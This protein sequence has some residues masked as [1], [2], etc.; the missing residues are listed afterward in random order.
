M[1]ANGLLN[2]RN[3]NP[4]NSMLSSVVSENPNQAST[5][6]PDLVLE[7]ARID[8]LESYLKD[9][10]QEG[11]NE[12]TRWLREIRL[13]HEELAWH[14]RPSVFILCMIVGMLCISDMM[15]RAPFI[16]LMMNKVCDNLVL[17]AKENS[18][19][20]IATEC[21]RKQVQQVLA[22]VTSITIITSGI[23]N[24]FLS[25]KWGAFSDRVGRTR[26]FAYIGM[27]RLVGISVLYYSISPSAPYNKWLLIIPETIQSLGGGGLTVIAIGNSY[28]LDIVEPEYR[29]VAISLMMSTLY[30]TMGLGPMISSTLTN[31]ST[32]NNFVPIHVSLLLLVLFIILC[33]LLLVE[34]R[35]NEAMN[36]S[37]L[38]FQQK[39][40]D[41]NDRIDEITANSNRFVNYFSRF[42][43]LQVMQ[44]KGLLSPLNTLWIKPTEAG[45]LK[46]RYTVILL[47][48]I[49]VL[50][51]CCTAAIMPGLVLFATY[52]FQWT[53]IELGYFVSVAGL[54]RAFVLLV[55]SP[56]LI[57]YLKKTHKV[58]TKIID[59]VD[60]L[61]IRL[62]LCVATLGIFSML[63]LKERY[64]SM[65]FFAIFQA[66]SA[67]CAPT[68]SST[69][70][71]YCPKITI[72]ESFGGIALVGSFVILSMSSLLL[73]IY[74]STVSFKP[75][76]FIY[77][78]LICGCLAVVLTFF[79]DSDQGSATSI[80]HYEVRDLSSSDTDN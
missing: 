59:D 41:M 43:Y 73:K 10:P 19:G 4:Y 35:H 14:S 57:H 9:E 53:S 8:M 71:K 36:R 44:A 38:M 42:I 11:G 50:F 23:T 37:K 17:H 15:V 74:G 30:G 2:S 34:P 80:P 66:L 7:Q 79:L 46:P 33:K 64:Q 40:N 16:T 48:I 25:G 68:L 32:G 18:K 75:E 3:S 47:I 76:L 60:I 26:V 24:T 31:I 51:L 20:A 29:T 54:G 70:I 78:P 22:D 28:L 69:I 1:S 13:C 72:G 67:V 63:L 39:N 21:D 61:C 5:E 45:S 65:L 62:S 49:D 58:S 55:L 56:I 27:I 6:P 52:Q 12:E 77:I